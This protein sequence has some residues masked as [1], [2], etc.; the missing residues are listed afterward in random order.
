[1]KIIVVVRDRREGVLAGKTKLG[2]HATGEIGRRC[3]RSDDVAKRRLVKSA[4]KHQGGP[5]GLHTGN[6]KRQPVDV[7]SLLHQ[8]QKRLPVSHRARAAEEI[9]REGERIAFKRK[10]RS[11]VVFDRSHGIRAKGRA[12]GDSEASPRVTTR[13]LAG[14]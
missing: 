8:E 5:I 7:A 13:I 9:D 4:I 12:C 3:T 1:M 11:I 14:G 10:V 6:A 2:R